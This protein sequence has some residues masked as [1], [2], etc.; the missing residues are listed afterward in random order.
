MNEEHAKHLM[1]VTGKGP[2]DLWLE[3]V[4]TLILL[5]GGLAVLLVIILLVFGL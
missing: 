4:G 2:I 5:S 1:K 3:Y